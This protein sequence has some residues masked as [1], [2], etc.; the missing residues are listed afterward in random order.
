MPCHWVFI[1]VQ[2]RVTALYSKGH[3]NTF[4]GSMFIDNPR[5]EA[6]N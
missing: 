1:Q 2:S 3:Y 6:L 4:A 5:I